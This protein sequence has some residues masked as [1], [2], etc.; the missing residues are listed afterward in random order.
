MNHYIFVNIMITQLR[1]YRKLFQ[2]FFSPSGTLHISNNIFSTTS[3]KISCSGLPVGF[4]QKKGQLRKAV[5]FI[6]TISI[7][8]AGRC[9][10][11]LR[12]KTFYAFHTVT[13]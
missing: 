4:G 9:S 7:Q 13:P 5:L 12:A 10:A 2:P 1:R 8:F 11:D 3:Y 6:Y